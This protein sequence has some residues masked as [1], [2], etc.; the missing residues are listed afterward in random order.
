[1]YYCAICHTN[2]YWIF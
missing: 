2:T 1:D